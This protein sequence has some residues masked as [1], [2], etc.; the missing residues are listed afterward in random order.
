MFGFFLKPVIDSNRLY[1][2]T[3]RAYTGT[4][5]RHSRSLRASCTDSTANSIS[6]VKGE[7]YGHAYSLAHSFC[8]ASSSHRYGHSLA[9]AHRCTHS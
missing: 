6:A 5:I 2:T 3:A 7:P 8:D 4:H 1:Y 9:C